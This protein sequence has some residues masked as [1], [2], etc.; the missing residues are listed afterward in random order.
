[1]T[2]TQNFTGHLSIDAGNPAVD[3]KVFD[4][5]F[6]LRA[7][8]S[9]RVDETLPTGFYTVRYSAGDAREEREITLRPGV[10][11]VLTEPPTLPFSSAAPLP[12]TSTS[13]PYH[14]TQ[15]SQLSRENPLKLGEGSHFFLFVRRR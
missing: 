10:P 3:I 15:A 4:G 7:S 12:L 1:M 13:S 11:V 8:G 9:G 14:Q 6:R 2:S 5:A